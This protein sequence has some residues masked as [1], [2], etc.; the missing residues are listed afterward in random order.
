M[1]RRNLSRLLPLA[2]LGSLLTITLAQAVPASADTHL[3]PHA[4]RTTEPLAAIDAYGASLI[5]RTAKVKVSLQQWDQDLVET[6]T[7]LVKL[8]T[9]RNGVTDHFIVKRAFS[10]DIYKGRPTAGKLVCVDGQFGTN[11]AT[12]TLTAAFAASCIG[13]PAAVRLNVFYS[14]TGKV[15]STSDFAPAAGKWSPSTARSASSAR[16]PASS[17]KPVAGV[18][19][20]K[21]RTGHSQ[22]GLRLAVDLPKRFHG[23]RV[24]VSARVGPK[25]ERL[26]I[27]TLNRLGDAAFRVSNTQAGNVH[28]GVTVVVLRG[29]KIL[30][31]GMVR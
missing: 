8:D 27:V 11:R 9:N 2:V 31:Q 4:S 20:L 23:A 18:P 15:D 17:A 14:L 7:L 28:K 21:M 12:G 24:A 16:P 19:T 22:S 3:F 10:Y 25:Y 30:A 5:G 29:G 6:S 26:G 13:S 1:T